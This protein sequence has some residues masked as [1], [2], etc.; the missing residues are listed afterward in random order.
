MFEYGPGYL[1]VKLF[2]L[3]AIFFIIWLFNRDA[4]KWLDE[5]GAAPEEWLQEKNLRYTQSEFE[6]LVAEALEEVPEEFAN[7]FKNV[8]VVTSSWWPS[9][10]VR[11]RM[12]VADNQVILG[13]YQG[14]HLGEDA[15]APSGVMNVITVY[16]PAIEIV[17]KTDEEIRQQVRK[18][19]L[20]ELAHRLG[21]THEK[22]HEVGL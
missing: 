15:R 7:A 22:M 16:Q 12:L 5:W 17:C 19:V 8:M 2:F 6:V 14:M 9:E 18:T 20:H 4:K 21:M 10:L 13:T 1:M 11:K 3:A